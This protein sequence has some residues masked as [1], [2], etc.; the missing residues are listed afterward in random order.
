MI[1]FPQKRQNDVAQKKSVILLQGNRGKD[2][3][4]NLLRSLNILLQAVFSVYIYL[5]LSG[6]GRLS[7]RYFGFLDNR[8]SCYYYCFCRDLSL[9]DAIMFLANI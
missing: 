5:C 6:K 1:S 9:R 2:T 8:R 7:E 4:K 3:K